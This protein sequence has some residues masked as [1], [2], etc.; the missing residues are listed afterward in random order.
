MCEQLVLAMNEN[1]SSTYQE[2]CLRALCLLP[3][4]K[5]VSKCCNA[6]DSKL[7]GARIERTLPWPLQR[8]AR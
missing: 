5:D 8:L 6:E 3:V 2:M 7:F 4:L 1:H